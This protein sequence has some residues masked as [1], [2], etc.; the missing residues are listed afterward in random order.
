MTNL[1]SLARSST[2][3][4]YQA[5]LLEVTLISSLIKVV[6]LWPTDSTELWPSVDNF[7]WTFI[8]FF[9]HGLHFY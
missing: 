1:S 2:L 3:P 6:S 7:F 8:L 5:L 4:Y 9:W